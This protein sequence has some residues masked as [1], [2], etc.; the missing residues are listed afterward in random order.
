MWDKIVPEEGDKAGKIDCYECQ[1]CDKKFKNSLEKQGPGSSAGRGSAICHVATDHGRLL[2]ALLNE[3]KDMT[4]EIEF[5]AE[6]D[7]GF[8]DAYHG[9]SIFHI[10]FIVT[11]FFLN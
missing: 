10:Y 7:K 1:V 4:K 11:I 6:H 5:L 2:D 3:D 9:E 8:N